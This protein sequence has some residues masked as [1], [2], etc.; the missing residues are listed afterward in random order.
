MQSRKQKAMCILLAIVIVL[1]GMCF[2]SSKADASFLYAPAEASDSTVRP[3]DA[4]IR[5]AQLCTTETL[6]I[7]DN[8][9]IQQ[10]AGRVNSQKRE[11]SDS[12]ALLYFNIL[13]SAAGKFYAGSEMMRSGQQYRNE[14]VANYIHR[15]DG[16]K[17]V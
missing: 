1:S 6:G 3:V 2:E 14:L 11:T 4:T 10:F 17:R 9:D 8:A 15:S 5:E 16:K 13:S 7:R 12:L